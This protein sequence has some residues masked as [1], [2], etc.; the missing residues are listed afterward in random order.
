MTKSWNVFPIQ[1][2]GEALQKL[3][4]LLYCLDPHPYLSLGAPY[5]KFADPWR[6]RSGVINRLIIAQHYLQVDNPSLQFAIFDAWRPISVQEFMV[7]H[8]IDEQC[9]LNGFNRKDPSKISELKQVCKEVQQFWASPTRDPLSP[10]PHST[11]AAVDLTLA[12]L[13]GNSLSMGG[14]IDEIGVVSSPDYYL[15]AADNDTDGK[16]WHKRR[17]LLSTVMKK[18]GFAQ[19]PNEWWH[20]SFGD[21][22]WAWRKK[23]PKAFYGAYEFL[24]SNEITF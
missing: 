18:A 11:G 17:E 21:Q 4:P 1:E 15:D 2:C 23:S 12:E 7:D 8:A 22:L 19:H 10:P 9:L 5:G 14:K 20:F 24:E 6:L 3:K 13:D 16:L